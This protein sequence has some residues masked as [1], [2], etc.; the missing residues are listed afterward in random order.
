MTVASPLCYLIRANEME[1]NVFFMIM[2]S[3]HIPTILCEFLPGGKDNLQDLWVP[4]GKA[5]SE[6]ASL[7]L[8]ESVCLQLSCPS[9]VRSSQVVKPSEPP[10]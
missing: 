7:I 5:D 8:K 3:F 2:T 1:P 10:S 6:P 4:E 9:T